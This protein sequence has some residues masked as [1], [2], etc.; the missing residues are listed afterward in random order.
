MINGEVQIQQPKEYELYFGDCLELMKEIPDKSINLVLTDP[1]YFSADKTRSKWDK[2]FDISLF[3]AEVGRV[4]KDNGAVVIFGNE[5]FSTVVR[6]SNLMHYK[7]DIKWIK[8]RATGFANA[9]YRPMNRYEDIMVFSKANASTGG[10]KNP[11][12]YFPQGLVPVNKTRKNTSNRHGSIMDDTN[13]TGKNNSLLQEGTIYIQKFTNYPSNVVFYDC[14]TTH[15]HPT[16]KP[17]KLL[18]YIINTFS[19]PGQTVLDMFMGSGSTG[20][21]CVNTGRKFIG[22]ELDQKYFEI[23]CER[24]EKI[25]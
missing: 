10:K 18:E 4:I 1:P 8:N 7:Y 22:M 14:D 13:N 6:H 25:S 20:V 17:V 19:E 12:Q 24:M 15:F 16:Q 21:A 2:G 5:P 3:W 23:A 11:M 9:N